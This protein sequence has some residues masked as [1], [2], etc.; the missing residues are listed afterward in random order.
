MGTEPE[1]PR[2]LSCAL[3]VESPRGWLM[4]RTTRRNRWD[5]P[6]GG[7]E[8]NETPQAAALREC[9][10]ETGLDWSVHAPSVEDL[11]RW[12]YLPTKD[13]HIFR[14]NLASAVDLKGC[15][16][17]T[18]VTDRNGGTPFPETD[19]WAWM[20]PKKARDRVGHGL[21]A[22]LDR[23]NLQMADRPPPSALVLARAPVWQPD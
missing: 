4:V 2:R 22:L 19:A 14:L 8:A 1:P 6:K 17:A 5:F 7:I 16:C 11:G 21:R 18:W 20:L 9:R 3:V 15:F 10:E 12:S 13:L 23:M